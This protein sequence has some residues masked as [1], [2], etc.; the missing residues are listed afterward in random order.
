MQFSFVWSCLIPAENIICNIL[1]SGQL[2]RK[3]VEYSNV[4][5]SGHVLS[6]LRGGSGFDSLLLMIVKRR[7]LE[8]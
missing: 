6:Q 1:L 5:L 3:Y 8:I 2:R 4:L 7:R